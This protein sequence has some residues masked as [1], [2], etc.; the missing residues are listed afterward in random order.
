MGGSGVGDTRGV[1]LW[2]HSPPPPRWAQVL[3]AGRFS[4][5]W[6]GTLQQRPVAIKA[7]A[8]G[9]A[10]RWAAERAVHELPLMEHENVAKLL[11]TR[12]AGPCARGGLLVLQL[13]P[14]V[15]AGEGGEGVWDVGGLLGARMGAHGSAS[16]HVDAGRGWAFVERIAASGR[17]RPWMAT[18]GRAAPQRHRSACSRRV[19]P[20]APHYPQLPP[21]AR[22]PPVP[23]RAPCSTSFASTSPRGPAVCAWRYPSPA[24]SPSCTR[25]CG[26]TV[27]APRPPPRP[28]TCDPAVGDAS[29]RPQGCTNPAWCTATSA[30]RTCWCA[31]TARAPSGTSGSPWRCRPALTA[32]AGRERRTSAG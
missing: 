28:P 15:S 8:A 18:W 25:S 9:A 22:P 2:G 21:P 3:Q 16:L 27:S 7:F 10:R 30:V 23:P 11:G 26:A 31:T 6:R 1:P 24:A 4:A 20:G 32:A 17:A 12:G 14:A 29:P 19:P 5:V 13:Y